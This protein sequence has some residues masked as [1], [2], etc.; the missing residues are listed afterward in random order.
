MTGLVRYAS[1]IADNQR[2]DGFELR[3][4]DI[5]TSTP[6]KCGTTWMQTLCSMLV[7]GEE[8]LDGP[9]AEISLWLDM[10]LDSRDDVVARL[11]AQQHRRFIKTHN[12]LDGL[13]PRPCVSA[14]SGLAASHSS[15][16][17]DP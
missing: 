10:L 9:L 4:D 1:F 3:G 11:N 15:W 13:P 6:S 16:S 2:W 14:S 17:R 12:P 7:L 8:P 5:V